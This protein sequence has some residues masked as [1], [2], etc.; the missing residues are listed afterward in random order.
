MDRLHHARHIGKLLI[1]NKSMIG[2]SSLPLPAIVHI[3]VGPSVLAQAAR[4]HG[5]SHPE[6]LLLR[7]MFRKA[8]P[9]AP[10]HGRS[11]SDL[12]PHDNPEFLLIRTQFVGGMQ[13]DGVDA[14]LLENSGDTSG[15]CI[16]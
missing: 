4:D 12:I 6:Y 5:F 16:D 9:T 7:D 11:K 3:N 8:V 10:S 2:A 1:S 14:L 15:I 13:D